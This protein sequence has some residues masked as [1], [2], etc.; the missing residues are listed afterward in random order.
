M[1]KAIQGEYN[2]NYNNIKYTILSI[3]LVLPM[4]AFSGQI[5]QAVVIKTVQT[6]EI[7]RHADVMK[8][9]IRHR[10]LARKTMV[11]AI[12]A[13]GLYG[14]YNLGGWYFSKDK[15]ND[16]KERETMFHTKMTEAND[17]LEQKDKDIVEIITLNAHLANKLQANNIPLKDDN[18]PGENTNTEGFFTRKWKSAKQW[19]VD[20]KSWILTGKTWADG[21]MHIASSGTNFM[22][23]FL[24]YTIILPKCTSKI[25]GCLQNESLAWYITSCDPYLAKIRTLLKEAE[26]CDE[27]FMQS[28]RV[29]VRPERKEFLVHTCNNLVDSTEQILGYMQMSITNIQNDTSQTKKEA[30]LTLAHGA[31]QR[32]NN[33][34][35]VLIHTIQ[36]DLDKELFGNISNV[37]KR[38]DKEIRSALSLFASAQGCIFE[39][40]CALASM[41]ELESQED[42]QFVL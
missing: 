17:A 20:T 11:A 8:K 14:A 42:V 2:M 15:N 13:V 7:Q 37:V 24:L 12:V 6:E 25:L 32:V 5:G 34:I 31:I 30:V 3:F 1:S 18:T 28:G 39:W 4:A 35:T 36:A 21:A 23:H 40:Q 26:D 33:A 16:F 29:G 9:N 22:K 19:G 10:S 41:N 38:F 27:L